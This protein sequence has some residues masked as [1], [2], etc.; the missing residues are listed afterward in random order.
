MISKIPLMIDCDP[1]H[2]DILAIM[3]ALSSEQLDLRAITCVMGNKSLDKVVANTLRTLT[4]LGVTHIPV[5]IGSSNPMIRPRLTG[6]GVVHGLTGLD[7]PSMPEPG[8]EPSKLS[9]VDLM[10]QVLET[11]EVPVTICPLGPLTNIAN[12]LLVRPDLKVKIAGLSLMGGGYA[13][14]NWTPQAEFNILADPEAAKIVFN[15]GLPIAMSGLDVTLK[16][17]LTRADIERLREA[18]SSG[19]RFAAELIDY[20]SR[21]HF[22]VEKLPGCT[23]HDPCAVAWLLHPDLFKARECSVDVECTGV[24]AVGKTVVDWYNVLGQTRNVDVL[25][26]VDR[27]AFVDRFIAAMKNLKEPEQ[28]KHEHL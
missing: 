16:A 11:A 13:I 27:E 14:G 3:W 9:A 12:L 25:Y 1:G 21:Y 26:D 19:A 20:F 5:G 17:Y 10:I 18:G 24:Y 15:S 8:F 4:R 22:E 2:D 7:G 28:L 23:L 6:G